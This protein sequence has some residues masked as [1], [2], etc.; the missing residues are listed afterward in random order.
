MA[1]TALQLSLVNSEQRLS[2]T[3][4]V[5]QLQLR[6][7]TYGQ[8]LERKILWNLW[9]DD[10]HC[11]W[12][13]Q[14]TR[15]S[16]AATTHCSNQLPKRKWVTPA[17]LFVGSALGRVDWLLLG[18][19]YFPTLQQQQ[20]A[21]NGSPDP[22]Y[23]AYNPDT[24]LEQWFYYLQQTW[25]N[26][27]KG[28]WPI[29]NYSDNAVAKNLLMNIATKQQKD[30]CLMDFNIPAQLQEVMACIQTRPDDPY[31]VF[32]E[33][34][35]NMPVSDECKR[36]C[37]MF[38]YPCQAGLAQCASS[39]FVKSFQ[40]DSVPPSRWYKLRASSWKETKNHNEMCVSECM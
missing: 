1:A 40:W 7:C 8:S 18:H 19:R 32:S 29:P 3:I 12:E 5:W 34:C 39:D 25:I 10:E 24:G 38:L 4:R 16:L 35:R 33:R 28:V 37:G 30:L 13:G 2:G 27:K 36:T 31:C 17:A 21:L 14:A 20:T 22:T 11:P 6:E 15:D 26:A 9:N 23:T